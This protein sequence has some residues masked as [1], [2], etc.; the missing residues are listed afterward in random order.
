V[1]VLVFKRIFDIVFSSPPPAVADRSTPIPATTVVSESE[2]QR[3][4]PLYAVKRG[5]KEIASKLFMAMST[6]KVSI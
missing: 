3:Q 1:G 2:Q 5:G 4:D 6:E